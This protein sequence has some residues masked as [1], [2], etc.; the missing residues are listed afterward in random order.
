MVS[1]LTGRD[2]DRL[3]SSFSCNHGDSAFA[4]RDWAVT[5]GAGVCGFAGRTGNASRPDAMGDVAASNATLSGVSAKRRN[6]A[7]FAGRRG[8]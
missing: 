6:S 8:I 5:P 4:G 2:S 1:R 3:R 7:A